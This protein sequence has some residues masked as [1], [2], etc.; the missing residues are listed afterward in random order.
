MYNLVAIQFDFGFNVINVNRLLIKVIHCRKVNQS[1]FTLSCTD[2]L[3]LNKLRCQ[4]NIEATKEAKPS[5][6]LTKQF[7]YT[8][9]FP[10]NVQRTNEK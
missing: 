6:H 10:I 2:H 1:T 5:K 7:L 9:C 8:T 4:Q 3:I